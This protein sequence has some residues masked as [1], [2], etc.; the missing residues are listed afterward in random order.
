[1]GVRGP[2]IELRGVL[3]TEGGG[4][5]WIDTMEE[6]ESGTD[7]CTELLE[8]PNTK[9]GADPLTTSWDGSKSGVDLCS[10]S[11]WES[12]TEAWLDCCTDSRGEL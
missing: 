5:P 6:S 12:G 2:G 9:G 10:D 11:R 7:A 3:S 1:M 4:D 8:R